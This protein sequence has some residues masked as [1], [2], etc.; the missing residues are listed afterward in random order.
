MN[1]RQAQMAGCQTQHPDVLQGWQR[2]GRAHTAPG[3]AV[4]VRR[5]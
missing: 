3:A 2:P 4:P 5:Q 1:P